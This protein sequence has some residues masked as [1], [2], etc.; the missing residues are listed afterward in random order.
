MMPS[1]KSK[2][3]TFIVTSIRRVFDDK[4]ELQLT[5]DNSNFCGI[6]IKF[7]F[8]RVRVI[9]YFVDKERKND[10]YGF[11]K[12]FFSFISKKNLFVYFR[13]L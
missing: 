10:K 7:E 3:S 5:F 1:I 11:R 8:S 6:L 9:E 2:K 12:G 4:F 13:S